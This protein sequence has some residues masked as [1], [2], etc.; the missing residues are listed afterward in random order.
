LTTEENCQLAS[1][2]IEAFRTLAAP[3]FGAGSDTIH[4]SE[5]RIVSQTLREWDTDS[6]L[7]N[8]WIVTLELPGQQLNVDIRIDRATG[9]AEAQAVHK[10]VGSQMD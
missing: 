10:A 6:L 8:W 2:A 4:V 9:A 5:A 7:G 1:A 3:P